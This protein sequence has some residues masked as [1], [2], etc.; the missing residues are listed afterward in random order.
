MTKIF[1][2]LLVV[3]GIS[4]TAFSQTKG[5]T[6]FGATIGYNASTVTAS[7]LTNSDYRS[8]FN[9]GIVADHYFSESW[10]IKVKALYDQKGW[11]SGYLE[12]GNGSYTTNYQLDY[13]TIPV[14]ANWHFGRTKNW[15]LNFGPY[16]SFLLNAKETANSMDVKSIFSSTDAGLDVGIGIKFPVSNSTKFFIE[17][18]GL[19]GVSDLVKDNQGSTLRSSVSAINIGLNF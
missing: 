2:T 12:T 18:N 14:M 7:G 8:G 3:L 15:Y 10:S 17:L 6:Q 16:L 9:I 5:T 13:L 19:A 11:N 4:T 1:T